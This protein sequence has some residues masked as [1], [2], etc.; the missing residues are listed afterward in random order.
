MARLQ[1]KRLSKNSGRHRRLAGGLALARRAGQH[2]EPETRRSQ[3]LKQ[4]LGLHDFRVTATMKINNWEDTG[5]NEVSQGSRGGCRF[6]CTGFAF[7]LRF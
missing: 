7:N 5:M 6:I 1:I 2:I 3:T 4:D